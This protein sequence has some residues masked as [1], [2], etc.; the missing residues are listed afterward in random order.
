M[1]DFYEVNF[2]VKIRQYLDQICETMKN[3]DMSRRVTMEAVYPKDVS[4]S[5]SSIFI[6]LTQK[7]YVKRKCRKKYC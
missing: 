1:F 5:V 7:K 4:S 6:I 2:Q 3:K